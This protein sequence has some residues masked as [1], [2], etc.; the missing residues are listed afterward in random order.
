[1]YIT[2]T[3]HN[4]LEFNHDLSQ[5]KLEFQSLQKLVNQV[6]RK[7]LHYLE[8]RNPTRFA[9]N[10]LHQARNQ[11]VLPLALWALELI[12]VMRRRVDM[13]VQSAQ[14]TESTVAEIAFVSSAVKCAL[15]HIVRYDADRSA[16]YAAR[17]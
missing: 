3:V 7:V 1:M 9:F 11:L 2:L 4:P 6:L 14:G 12:R 15:C 13:G 16:F 10:M 17:D 8:P 5:L